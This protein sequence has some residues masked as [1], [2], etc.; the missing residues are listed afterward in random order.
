M[1]FAGMH[2]FRLTTKNGGMG[3]QLNAYGVVRHC[4][5]KKVHKKPYNRTIKTGKPILIQTN[6]S[7]NKIMRIVQAIS[8]SR[9]AKSA[10]KTAASYDS[11]IRKAADEPIKEYM[12]IAALSESA[13][14][15]NTHPIS[16]TSVDK[17]IMN[18]NW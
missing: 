18:F 4:I 3:A 13:R 2:G 15:I 6:Q 14:N 16:L 5:T 9:K 7:R 12:P 1:F 10:E 17:Q 8:K 11:I